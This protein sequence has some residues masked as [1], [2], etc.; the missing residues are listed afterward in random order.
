[1]PQPTF[2]ALDWFF[3]SSVEIVV[4]FH[5][6]SFLSRRPVTYRLSKAMPTTAGI[7]KG[8]AGAPTPTSQPAKHRKL[9]P[10]VIQPRAG[11]NRPERKIAHPIKAI[12]TKLPT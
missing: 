9:Q 1:M 3:T 6:L 12:A 5:L 10:I 2:A 8:T 7:I 4:T 11:V